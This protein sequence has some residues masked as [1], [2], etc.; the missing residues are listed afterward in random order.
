MEDFESG[1][2]YPSSREPA[3]ELN[4]RL[5]Q[6]VAGNH[7]V[8]TEMRSLDLKGPDVS[9]GI[10]AISFAFGVRVNVDW[11]GIES[12]KSQP[13]ASFWVDVYNGTMCEYLEL[14]FAQ[15]YDL[16][17]IRFSWDGTAVNIDSR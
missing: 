1:T 2:H 13:A 6:A 15:T 7:S 16:D 14:L 10:Q 4:R 5:W 12:A 8:R 9:K 3:T 11:K 17:H